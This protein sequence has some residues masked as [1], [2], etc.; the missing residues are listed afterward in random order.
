M[1]FWPFLMG[2]TALCLVAG[3][4]HG[5][6][7]APLVILL[8]Y[9]ATRGAVNHAYE[10][11]V[12]IGLIWIATAGVVAL[13]GSPWVAFALLASG[14]CYPVFRAY[15]H[16]IEHLGILPIASEVFGVAGL[17]LLGGGSFGPYF[18][19][20]ASSDISGLASWRSGLSAYRQGG[21]EGHRPEVG[22]STMPTTG[23]GS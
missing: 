5:R 1:P 13:L 9:A 12:T 17:L 6:W 3:A 22:A 18:P 15:G 10:P 20:R 19:S 2:F 8:A 14:L 11:E 16:Q 7:Q 21:Q 23:G 4:F